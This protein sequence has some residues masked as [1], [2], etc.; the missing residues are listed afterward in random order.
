MIIDL[1][2]QTI[3]SNIIKIQAALIKSTQAAKYSDKS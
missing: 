1:I 3:F 2:S